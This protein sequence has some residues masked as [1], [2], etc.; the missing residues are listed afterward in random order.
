M[1]SIETNNSLNSNRNTATDWELVIINNSIQQYLDRYKLIE[2]GKTS[3]RVRL[4]L[5]PYL[6][7]IL[8]IN[9]RFLRSQPNFY[10]HKLNLD[11]L[12]LPYLTMNSFLGKNIYNSDISFKT[13]HIDSFINQ[14]V[15]S[16]DKVGQ[17][18]RTI[19]FNQLKR[20]CY[21]LSPIMN[22]FS[23][24]RKLYINNCELPLYSFNSILEKLSKLKV[25]HLELIYLLIA[26]EDSN[27]SNNLTFPKNLNSLS[28]GGAKLVIT[29]HPTS[30]TIFFISNQIPIYEGTDLDITLQSLPMLEIFRYSN[31]QLSTKLADFLGLNM[32]LESLILCITQLTHS[33]L[34]ML[35]MIPGLKRLKIESNNADF[36]VPNIDPE[37]PKITQLKELAVF[38]S[39]NSDFRFIHQFIVYTPNLT[40]LSVRSINDSQFVTFNDAVNN[41]NYFTNSTILY[42][43]FSYITKVY[44]K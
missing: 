32:Q 30:N 44:T 18:C 39:S 11:L 4:K 14:A 7:N 12:C 29:D 25:L 10:H 42:N 19:C 31:S 2:L 3:K 20:D 15:S 43:G 21:F 17:Y 41:L 35:S 36:E 1:D 37:S 38:I 16:L 6:F 27:L 13:I 9:A 28:Y 40:Q 34:S 8:N 26:T 5:Y 33:T 24:L 23:N 22:Q